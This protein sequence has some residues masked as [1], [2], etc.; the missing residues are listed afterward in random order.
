MNSRPDYAV[1]V[2]MKST[3]L[4]FAFCALLAPAVASADTEHVTRTIP[5]AP[6]GTLRLRTF[7]G[8]VTITA[9]DV[10][11]VSVDAVRRAPSDRLRRITLDVHADG[12]TVVVDANHREPSWFDMR[13]NVVE[14]DLDIKVPRRTS[15]DLNTFSAPITV[16][17]VEGS[18][19]IHGFSSRIRLNNAAG[20]V[21]A[22]T[23]SGSVEIHAARWLDPE[24]IDIDTFSGN[25]EL[26]VP[27]DARGAVTFNSFSG[28]LDSVLPLMMHSTSR[29]SIR[30]DL[31]SGGSNS[32]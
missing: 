7:S 29:R 18:Y 8:R 16:D 5:L 4:A 30:A 14:T 21:Q 22:H 26:R 19:K 3:T 10:S 31:G 9:S 6:G 32:R 25:V 2:R 17:G 13:N 24:T 28:R 12:S 27:E 23:F 11:E 1:K 20:S 15:L